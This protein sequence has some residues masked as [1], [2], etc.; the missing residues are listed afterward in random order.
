[1]I[2]GAQELKDL[3]VDRVDGVD[4]PATG[5]NFQNPPGQ[6]PAKKLAVFSPVLPARPLFPPLY[7]GLEACTTL[8][9]QFSRELGEGERELGELW[10][11][12]NG[13]NHGS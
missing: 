1:M 11:Q 12:K 8:P 7:C 10:R 9:T 3:D 4:K 13:G 2:K 6:I 5:R